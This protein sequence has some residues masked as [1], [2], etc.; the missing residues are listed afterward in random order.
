MELRGTAAA[1]PE[2]QLRNIDTAARIG[3]KSTPMGK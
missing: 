3:S 1:I 2:L